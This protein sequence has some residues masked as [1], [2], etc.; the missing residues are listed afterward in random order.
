LSEEEDGRKKKRIFFLMEFQSRVR[1]LII[2]SFHHQ[3]T[4]QYALMHI[5]KLYISV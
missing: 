5:N 1:L 4:T 3:T 2:H